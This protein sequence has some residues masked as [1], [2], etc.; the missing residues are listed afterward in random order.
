MAHSPGTAGSRS[1]GGPAA[2]AGLT[3]DSVL[4]GLP[5]YF[6]TAGAASGAGADFAGLTFPDPTDAGSLESQLGGGDGGWA[7]ATREA[8]E[9]LQQFV[10]GRV[11]EDAAASMDVDDDEM[12]RLLGGILS[13]NTA[14]AVGLQGFDLDGA[15]GGS[16][17]A[18]G[19]G[20]GL[21]AFRLGGDDDD[22][23]SAG[24]GGDVTPAEAPGLDADDAAAAAAAASASAGLPPLQPLEEAAAHAPPVPAP[25]PYDVVV[26][27]STSTPPAGP[28]AGVWMHAPVGAHVGKPVQTHPTNVALAALGDVPHA[29][30]AEGGRM[31]ASD[32]KYVATVHAAQRKRSGVAS[33]S[34]L[35]Y[36]QALRCKRAHVQLHAHRRAVAARFPAHG[37][38][39]PP[40]QTLVM[41][42]TADEAVSHLAAAEHTSRVIASKRLGFAASH[43]AIAQTAGG[44][45]RRP[46]QLLR[47]ERPAPAA[48]DAAAAAAGSAAG[49]D[50]D[51]DDSHALWRARKAVDDVFAALLRLADTQLALD[52]LRARTMTPGGAPPSQEAMARLAAAAGRLSLDKRG[53]AAS[54]GLRAPTPA[55]GDA[56]SDAPDFASARDTLQLLLALP[57][58]KRLL[59]RAVP[60][61]AHEDHAACLA[62]L[63]SVL[64]AVVCSPGESPEEQA[65]DAFLART[66]ASWIAY[67]GPSEAAARARDDADV[68][69][70]VT[71]VLGAFTEANEPEI[72][73]AL[74]QLP[75]G[76]EVAQ[77]LLQRGE[78]EQQHVAR[79]ADAIEAHA[80]ASKA[81][82][83]EAQTEDAE[84]AEA[85]AQLQRIAGERVAEWRA[86]VKGWTDLV[87]RLGHRV[88]EASSA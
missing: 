56:A 35:F 59:V 61:L 27:R 62:V 34:S 55:D 52:A 38:P 46:R 30:Q 23:E 47:L 81:R 60:K 72:L 82:S 29:A 8:A 19:A 39:P 20:D 48:R 79:A 31:S 1:A 77:A 13:S 44:N 36:L 16:D 51:G 18:A 53:V 9:G 22:A 10:S 74:L 66:Y 84:Q 2:C 64:V 70:R 25:V 76:N 63:A 11:A 14:S 15:L 21:V 49:D 80:A 42:L 67:L 43:R 58:G 5:S 85:A 33:A 86:A 24:L 87:E 41:P 50:D 75:L 83:D 45:V 6:R 3:G 7:K 65:S 17:S 40:P 71:A 26:V 54:L 32:V 73:A 28:G 68:L 12:S 69:R 4:D 88:A 57:K 78:A 37:P